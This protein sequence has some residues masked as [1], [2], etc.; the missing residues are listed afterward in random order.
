MPKKLQTPFSTRQYMLSRDFELYYYSDNQLTTV[1]SHSHSYYE[2]YIFLEGQLTMYVDN[3]PLSPKTGDVLLIPP[4]IPHHAVNQDPSVPYRRFVFWV[5][6]NYFHQLEQ[7]SPSYSYLMHH[8]L[9]SH[10]YQFHYDIVNF[11]TLQGKLFRLIEEMHSQHYG[12]E[13]MIS[14]N[15]CDLILYLNRTAYEQAHPHTPH[16]KQKLYEGLLQYIEGHLDE[17]L[18]LEHLARNFYVS[19]YHIA[20]VFKENLGISIHQYITKKRLAMCRDAILS[21]TE[22]QKGYLMYG[23][24]DYSSFFLA[25][26]KE[27]GLSPKEYKELFS[28]QSNVSSIGLK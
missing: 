26:R 18:T 14:L 23:F 9:N 7:L 17:D 20:H 21:N 2:F 1:N 12:R 27:Y 16:M 5:S 24:K 22:I 19:K 28:S 3:T 10:W 4:Q 6:C 13:A 8:A 15:V 25:F 11:H